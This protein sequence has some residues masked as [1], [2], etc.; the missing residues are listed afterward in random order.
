M[1]NTITYAQALEMAIKVCSVSA[2]ADD[3]SDVVKKLTALKEKYSKPH[4][5]SDEAKAKRSAMQKEKTAK[6]R[7]ELVSTVAPVLRKYLTSD[8]TAKEL[9]EVAKDELPQ[10]F[11]AAKVQNIL[12]REMAPELVKTETKGHANTYRLVG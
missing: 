7:A 6:A 11:S 4:T 9:F 1:K 2:N 10:G 3:Y 5:S 12:I 8:I